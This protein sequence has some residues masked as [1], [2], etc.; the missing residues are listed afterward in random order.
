VK[1][2]PRA[3]KPR[4]G[5]RSLRATLFVG[6]A[7]TLAPTASAA[8]LDPEGTD[9]DGL[10][11]L[12]TLARA[13]TA[14]DRVVAPRRLAFEDLS[15][16]DALLII[17][18]ETRL[19]A[20]AIESFVHAGG[21]VALLDDYGTGGDLLEHF[22]IRRVALP[23]NPARML[24]TNP[25]LALA[26]IPENGPSRSDAPRLLRESGPVV[27]NHAT[28]LGDTGLS[29]LLVVRGRGEPDVTLAVVGAFG[30]GGFLAIGDSS[31]AMNAMLRYPGNRALAVALVQYLSGERASSPRPGRLYVLA[32]DAALGGELAAPTPVPKSVRTGMVE[33]LDAFEQGLPPTAT[34]IA[35]VGMGLGIILWASSRA[36]RTYKESVPRFVRPI[37]V[38]AQGGFAG[39]M[40]S[41]VSK[42][43]RPALV[44]LRRALEEQIGIRL[45]LD[46]PAPYRELVARVRARGMLGEADAQDLDRIFGTL[47]VAGDEPKRQWTRP[48]R[49]KRAEVVALVERSRDLLAAMDRGR[50]DRL[51]AS[52]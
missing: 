14:R 37:P 13:E 36:G 50:R 3:A 10:A 9:W 29:P 28:G 11:D 6:L 39:K 25:S 52:P 2:L 15:P 34:Y 30:R 31:V 1:T 23:S 21:R 18:P 4:G 40:A 35:A 45:G 47:R 19:D 24:R 7:L 51:R 16:T 26:E 12:L 48:K 8:S 41:L 44:E 49:L 42:S 43:P 46:R 20:S 27:T 32:N 17:H 22:D 33:T 5:V 38:T